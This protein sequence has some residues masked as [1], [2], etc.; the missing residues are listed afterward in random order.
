MILV[1]A[2]VLPWALIFARNQ[3][4]VDAYFEGGTLRQD[5]LI[6]L[7]IILQVP[8]TILVAWG[9]KPPWQRALGI[10]VANNLFFV[11]GWYLL[12]VEIYEICRENG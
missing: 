9:F 1:I 11:V 2:A 7:A 5:F 12:G 10:F 6:F 4:L 3:M 8:L